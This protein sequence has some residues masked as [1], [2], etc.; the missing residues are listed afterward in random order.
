ME[1]RKRGKKRE[2]KTERI[3]QEAKTRRAMTT[4]RTTTARVDGVKKEAKGGDES[5][6]RR[7]CRR[8]LP[9]ATSKSKKEWD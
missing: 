6:F 3:K 8:L 1:Q 5:S 7:R 4:T 2:E 9:C